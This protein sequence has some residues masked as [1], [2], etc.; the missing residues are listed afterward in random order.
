MILVFGSINI[1]LVIPVP[2]LPRAGETQLGSDYALLP[3]GKGANQALA[4]RR[5]GSEVALVGAVGR[6]FF[7]EKALALLRR[8]K[9]DLRH[10]REVDAPTG[11]ATIAVAPSGENVIAVASGANALLRSEDT[12]NELL[13]EET[14]LLAQMEVPFAESARLIARARERGA[15]V[16]LNLAPALPIEEALLGAIDLLVANEGE[17]SSLGPDPAAVARRLRQGLVVTR[18]E[19]GALAFLAGGGRIEVPALAVEPV[20]TTNCGDVFVGVLA[21]ALD[22]GLALASALRRASAAAGLA[23]LL[24]GAQDAAPDA[25]RIAQA[26]ARL[27]P[28]R[29][30]KAEARR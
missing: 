6:D 23:A 14:I 9:V 27:A 13:R 11:L 8:E 2:R 24:R 21:A 25:V 7:A 5:A 12:P 29:E 18:G 3:G 15:R 20:D 10:L 30:T 19:R 28:P 22:A 17:A 26:E 4:A 1:D 16:L